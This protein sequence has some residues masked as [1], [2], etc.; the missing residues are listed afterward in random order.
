MAKNNAIN[1]DVTRNADGFTIAG[2]TTERSITVTGGDV[3]LTGNGSGAVITFPASTSTL[4]TLALSETLTN[5]TIDGDSNILSN[6]DIGLE[7]D[8]AVITD[9]ADATAFASGDKILIFEAG[10]GMRKIDY[11]D[12]PSG[13]GSGDVTAASSFGTDNVL[14]KSD[15]TGKGVQATGITIADTTDAMSGMSSI[16]LDSSGSILFGAVTILSDSAG[17]TTLSNIDAIDAT[18]GATIEAAIDTLTL[19]SL[20]MTTAVTAI[21]DEDTMSSNSATA[22]ATQQSIKAYVDSV[23]GIGGSTGGTDNTV[24]RADGTGG[25]TVQASSVI[26]DDSNHM[27]FGGAD[28][29]A[30]VDIAGVTGATQGLRISGAATTDLSFAT[31]VSGDSFLRMSF[32]PD[33]YLSWGGGT[34]SGD[35][36]LFRDSAN[37]LRTNDALTVDSTLTASGTIELGNASDTTLSR[38]SAGVLAVEGVVIP[39][40]SSTSTLTNKRVTKRVGTTTSSATPTIN[41]DNYDAYHLTDQA[42]DITSFT[43][44]LSGTPTNF[45]QL[46]ISITGTAARAITW[47]SSF[48]NGPVALPTTTVTT[49]RLDVLLEYSTVSSKWRCMASGSTV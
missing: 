41:T 45:Q 32:R 28:G 13:G 26:L 9:V 29:T 44:N 39:S 33:G 47:G 19:S 36:N 14:I 46:R 23:S 20:T 12:L 21:L 40:I 22:L 16:T 11:D 7:V 18:T 48:E 34:T 10:V 38:S 6:L 4:A 35:T 30:I 15:G 2:G 1:T 27:R 24:L 3:T 25:S 43:T 42:V 8:W 31:Y 49:T 37:V 17:T 5:K